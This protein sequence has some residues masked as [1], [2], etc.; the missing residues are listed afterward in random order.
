MELYPVADRIFIIP[1]RNGGRF[2]FSH[3]VYVE[4]ERRVLLDAGAGR[5]VM[6]AFLAEHP[7]DVVVAS[8]GHPGHLSGLFLLGGRPIFAPEQ[9]RDSFG[10]L[11]RLA[12]RFVAD[13]AARGLWTA[14]QRKVLGFRDTAHTHTYN[15]QTS[16]DLGTARL[17]AIHTPGH[18]VDHHGFYEET[19]GTLL[20]FDLD[21]DPGG[22]FYV[23]RESSLEDYRASLHLVRSYEARQV[24]LSHRGVLRTGIPEAIDGALAALDRRDEQILAALSDEPRTLDRLA[25][26][27]LLIPS[28]PRNLA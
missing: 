17:H 26:A 6:Q 22:M 13:P 21:L 16:L 14:L 12:E 1:G 24:V 10:H 15:G 5:D 7:V 20:A 19:T 23:H 4:G 28:P 18:T 11:E 27:Q 9:S 8:H 2:P 25:D 3:A